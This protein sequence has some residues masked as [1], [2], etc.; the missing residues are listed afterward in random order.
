MNNIRKTIKK[1]IKES[2]S[3]QNQTINDFLNY[4]K[5]NTTQDQR[6]IISQRMGE[7]PLN[8]FSPVDKQPIGLSKGMAAGRTD[9]TF[10]RIKRR[11]D[12]SIVYFKYHAKDPVTGEKLYHSGGEP[13]MKR[14]AAEETVRAEPD[15][16]FSG[17]VYMFQFELPGDKRLVS[18]V[19]NET[20]IIQHLK[21]YGIIAKYKDVLDSG[22]YV[23][24][25]MYNNPSFNAGVKFMLGSPRDRNL[26][27]C[28]KE[29]GRLPSSYDI[30]E[31]IKRIELNPTVKKILSGQQQIADREELKRRENDES[32]SFRE[33]FG[34]LSVEEQKKKRAEFRNRRR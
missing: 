9:R 15:M 27:A 18:I 30:D 32:L 12:G 4:L 13:V 11:D 14:K 5:H 7:N 31:V 22:V 8:Y 28:L 26:I 16:L 20:Y 10:K 17:E 19:T 29:T 3:D 34:H 24:T 25:A 23:R 1:L 33:R 2:L 21:Q 6:N